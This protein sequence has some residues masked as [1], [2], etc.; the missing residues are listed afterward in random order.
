MLKRRLMIAKTLLEGGAAPEKYTWEGVLYHINKG[1]Y[2]SAYSIGDMIPL[3]L[4][5]EGQLNAQIADFNHDDL[6]DGTGK[7]HISFITKELC[8]TESKMNSTETNAGGWRDSL[9]RN[10][11][12][13][14]IWG[15]L[16]TIL[17]ESIVE[18]IKKSSAGNADTTI[19]STNDKLWIPSIYEVDSSYTDSIYPDEG[20][21][22]PI[23]TD[24]SSR[25]KKRNG[26]VYGWWTRSPRI[27]SGAF[28]IVQS[29]GGIVGYRTQYE[30]GV[31]LGFCM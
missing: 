13:S 19:I 2:A 22:Y 3:N 16:P 11:V 10:T 15:K 7:A 12:M 18:V 4:G 17:Q 30:Q 14:S 25:V 5:T 24:K 20:T 8:S 9:I 21:T 29:G 26:S 27:E 23:F 6:A 28:W 1:D 31:V